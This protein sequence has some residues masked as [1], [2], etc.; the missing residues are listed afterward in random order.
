MKIRIPSE[1]EL[2]GPRTEPKPGWPTCRLSPGLENCEIVDD[3]GKVIT[4]QVKSIDIRMRCGEPIVAMIERFDVSG[5]IHA[6]EADSTR[7][8][9]LLTAEV[10][11][12]KAHAERM[13]LALECTR[14][15]LRVGEL[16]LEALR[17]IAHA[18]DIECAE[19][20]I[21]STKSIVDRIE[22][23]KVKP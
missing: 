6:I 21:V 16:A 23:L 15:G 20:E 13:A 9:E 3:N 10:A 1:E 22:A 19:G 12:H 7:Q 4:T 5:E 18:V 17:T 11:G 8:I 14:D 2:N